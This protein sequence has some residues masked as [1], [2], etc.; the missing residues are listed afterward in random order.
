VNAVDVD[1]EAAGE[2]VD[3]E[4]GEADVIHQLTLQPRRW[5]W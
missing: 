5:L 4:L 2:I 3:Q 1:T